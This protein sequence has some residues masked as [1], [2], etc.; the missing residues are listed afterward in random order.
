MVKTLEERSS[1]EPSKRSMNWLKLKKDYMDEL[2]DSVD[3]VVV[4]GDYGRGKRTGWFASFL[5]A[6]FNPN[7]G[8]YETICKC[9]TG[10][11]HDEFAVLMERFEKESL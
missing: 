2:G 10:I 1:Y 7:S 5:L 3:L 11:T 8:K 9:G 6:C 4:G